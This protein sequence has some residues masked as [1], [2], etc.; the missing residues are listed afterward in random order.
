[1]VSPEHNPISRPAVS[2]DLPV[3]SDPLPF[4]D[5]YSSDNRRLS[6]GYATVSPRST[7]PLLT[8]ALSSII[9]AGVQF[10]WALQ[11]SL[12]TPYIQTLG[13]EHAFTSFIW[14]CGPITGLVVQPCVGVWSDKC[15]LRL[16][17]RRP[18][19]IGGALL[20]CFAV[21]IIGFAA[22][23][24][25]F[26]GDNHKNCNYPVKRPRAVGV[27]IV[28]FWL[29]DLANNTVQGPARALLA[30]LAGPEQRDTANAI[31]CLWMAI[32]NII[33]FSTGASGSWSRVFPFV[34]TQACCVPCGNLK[35]AF[36][37]AVVFL[38]LCTLI[39]V[40]FAKEIPL[41]SSKPRS[42]EDTSPLLFSEQEKSVEMQVVRLSVEINHDTLGDVNGRVEF[43]QASDH[44]GGGNIGAGPGAVLV[45]LLT[46][47]RQL[48]PEMKSVL[49]VMA[50]CWLSWFPFFLF[51][52]D[53]M[54]REV[55]HGDPLGD[56]E[57]ANAYQQGVQR[58]AVG[59]LLNSIVLAAGSFFI[60]PLCKRLGSKL[61]WATSNF[62]IFI[63]MGST[64]VISA[65]AA[66]RGHH[67]YE[68]WAKSAAIAV[69]ALLGLP[70]AVTYSV[71]YSITAELASES[72]GGQG[73]AMGVLNLAVVVPQMIV[74]LGA[75]P[76]DDLF[77]G[78]NEPA[79]GFAALFAFTAGVIA[80]VKLPQLAEGGY[81]AAGVAHGFG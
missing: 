80:W 12:L 5:S 36:L 27:F 70:L 16:G 39:T 81:R 28:G 24:G 19:I 20:I 37:V 48:P 49:L 9:A 40:F 2:P 64:A 32:G 58:G 76:W 61:V 26:L 38:A 21:I 7:T 65:L 55:F 73:L 3:F 69:F 77:G 23:I 56:T 22:D 30:D 25:Y 78:G 75:G 6:N 50:L 54:G 51:D 44:E 79:F 8:L 57:K 10:G 72:G 45:N 68:N 43:Q 53:W 29:L 33:G 60:D 42:V 47:I 52:T 11:L 35:A 41:V 66:R 18:F 31:F 71:P 17:R 74:A 1:M 59:L 67:M 63:G 4:P 62:M 14:L 34:I 13:I 15:T 46:S